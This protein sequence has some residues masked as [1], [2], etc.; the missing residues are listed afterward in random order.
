MFRF[1]SF[2]DSLKIFSE[3][4]LND[5]KEEIHFNNVLSGVYFV[6][7][8]DGENNYCKKLIVEHD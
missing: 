7:V 4:I 2:F 3:K 5:S 8:F 1:I 6:K